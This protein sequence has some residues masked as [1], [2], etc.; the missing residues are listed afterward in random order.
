M[1]IHIALYL[2]NSGHCVEDSE[3]SVSITGMEFRE[4]MYN[5]KLTKQSDLIF[6]CN[7]HNNDNNNNVP[8]I[9]VSY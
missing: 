2:S 1:L 7:G 3:Y 5:Y 4:E 9:T 8:V 6:N